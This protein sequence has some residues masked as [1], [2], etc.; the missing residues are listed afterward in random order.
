MKRGAIYAACR[1]EGYNVLALGQ[2]LDDLAESFL[3]GAFLNGEL[4]AMKACYE[5]KE[6]VEQD[7][8]P[9][10][11]SLPHV[12]L[13]AEGRTPQNASAPSACY[14]AGSIRVIRPLVY[15]REHLTGEFAR[16]SRLPVINENC[17]ACFEAP[18]ERRRVKKLLSQQESLFPATFQNLRRAMIPL[19]G[20]D[21]TR[22]LADY[23]AEKLSAGRRYWDPDRKD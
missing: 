2:H 22:N 19:M 17:P 20:P 12:G 9:V 14:Y 23:A 4:R 6:G 7:Q 10:N 21:T 1:R 18:Q 8:S 5:T 13:S 11:A 15:V 16:R 3:M